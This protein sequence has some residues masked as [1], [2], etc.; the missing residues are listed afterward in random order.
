MDGPQGWRIEDAWILVSLDPS[1]LLTINN[2]DRINHA[3]PN[4][5]ELQASLGRLVGSGLAE[6]RSSW[7][8]RTTVGNRLVG[9]SVGG[10]NDALAVLSRLSTVPRTPV[11]V[12]V[13]RAVFERAV[14][15]STRP[16]A[17][18]R[19]WRWIFDPRHSA[20]AHRR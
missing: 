20:G 7:F 17:P 3:I 10:Y 1:P 15:D 12:Q 4:F 11:S 8:S 9:R 2:A 5:A 6:P 16:W 18:G 14:S 19:L 13:D